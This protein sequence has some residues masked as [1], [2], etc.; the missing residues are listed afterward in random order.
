MNT[1]DL[2]DTMCNALGKAFNVPDTVTING[3]EKSVPLSKRQLTV[4]QFVALSSQ[5]P[6]PSVED[7]DMP[8]DTET[9]E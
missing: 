5:T 3:I 9:D 2:A 1:D 8:G 7:V 6:G 4:D